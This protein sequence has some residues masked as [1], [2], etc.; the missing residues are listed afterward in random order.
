MEC[1]ALEIGHIL[2]LQRSPTEPVSE[3]YQE[4][5]ERKWDQQAQ[6]DY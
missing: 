2:L 5:S 4:L 3:N 1:F 6:I